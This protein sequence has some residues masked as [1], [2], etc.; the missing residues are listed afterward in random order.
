METVRVVYVIVERTS[1]NH[2]VPRIE[3]K[4][5]SPLVPSRRRRR[6]R[7]HHARA[8]SN[9][10]RYISMIRQ[11]MTMVNM[12][13]EIGTYWD[14]IRPLLEIYCIRH[15]T[16]ISP[17]YIKPDSPFS[18]PHS[19]PC[20]LLLRRGIIYRRIRIRPPRQRVLA[21]PGRLRSHRRPRRRR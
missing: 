8:R 2:D 11:D 4:S 17:I 7:R 15:T 3:A 21:P 14:M 18:T 6:H 16:E 9:S 19:F 10:R 13:Y 5:G 1:G 12:A 20:F